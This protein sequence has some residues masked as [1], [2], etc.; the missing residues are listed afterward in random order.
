MRV[1]FNK[2]SESPLFC[3]FQLSVNHLESRQMT[4]DFCTFIALAKWKKKKGKTAMYLIRDRFFNGKTK[5]FRKILVPTWMASTGREMLHIGNRKTV[6][7]FVIILSWLW[8]KVAVYLH[9]YFSPF[10]L[11]LRLMKKMK[12][13]RTFNV[14]VKQWI[15]CWRHFHQKRNSEQCRVSFFL[16]IVL[17]SFIV[18]KRYFN[19]VF[20]VL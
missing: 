4:A 11:F 17:Y 16:C 1:W 19:I 2:T 12:L 6:L 8:W 9:C 14:T 3:W 10:Q 7:I 13:S 15:V 20:M 18:L 5:T